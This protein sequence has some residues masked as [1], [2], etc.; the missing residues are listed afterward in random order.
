[1]NSHPSVTVLI[2]FYNSE[3]YLEA[4]IDS[5]LRQTFTDLE[6]LL[7][8]D[9]S[10]DASRAIVQGYDDPRIRMI[11][12][13]KNQGVVYS[14]NK[15][16]QEAKAPLVAVLDA[17][18]IAVPDRIASQYAYMNSHPQLMMVGGHAEVINAEGKP[19]GEY[20]KMP[21]GTAAVPIELL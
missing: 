13:D 16:V 11:S 7:V 19:T 10:T 12:N 18:D 4:A 3:A 2:P 5:V 20:Y 15:G 14:R 8:D 9:G 1:M 6:V 17:D 21:T